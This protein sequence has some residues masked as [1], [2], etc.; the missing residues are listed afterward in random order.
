MDNKTT[1]NMIGKNDS[2]RDGVFFTELSISQIN[3]IY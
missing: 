3:N 2:R 1:R